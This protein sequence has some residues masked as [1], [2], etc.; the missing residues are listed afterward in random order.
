MHPSLLDHIHASLSPLMVLSVDTTFGGELQVMGLVDPS[1]GYERRDYAPDGNYE[2][3]WWRRT[4]FAQAEPAPRHQKLPAPDQRKPVDARAA[5]SLIQ[6]LSRIHVPLGDPHSGVDDGVILT[7]HLRTDN[8]HFDLMWNA[9]GAPDDWKD[10]QRWFDAAWDQMRA[11][12][13]LP[14][15]HDALQYSR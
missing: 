11:W 5:R 4:D 3:V 2:V 13:D 14:D 15:G 9:L 1:R 7:L 6:S 12:L 10:F 8:G